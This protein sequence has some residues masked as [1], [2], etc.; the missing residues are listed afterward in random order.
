ME[1]LNTESLLMPLLTAMISLSVFPSPPQIIKDLAANEYVRWLFVL[2][3]V[4]AVGPAQG[5]FTL[6]AVTTVIL[7]ILTK[8]L[9]MAYVKREG[10]YN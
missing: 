10:Y 3:L 5:N 1:Y 4:Y 9:D 6:A 2:N 7:F 8:V